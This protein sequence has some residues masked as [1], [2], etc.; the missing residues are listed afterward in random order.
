MQIPHAFEE[1]MTHA[2]GA[3][4]HSFRASLLEAPPVSIRINP[5]KKYTS[6]ESQQIPWCNQGRYLSK[7][8]SFT[9]DP[10]LHAGA[11]YVQEASS[12]FLE[13]V[14]SA[15]VNLS[16]PIRV[17]DLCAA[18]GGKSTH[19]L[20][21]LNNESLLVSNEVIRSRASILTEN[22]QKWGHANVVV[23]NNDPEGFQRVPG[24]FDVIIV[25]APCSGEGL[26][27]KDPSAM[28]EWSVEN[29]N[30]CSL[31]QRRILADVWAALKDGG[32]LIYSTC[33][34]NPEENEK[35]LSWFA[36]ENAIEFVDIGEL[37]AGVEKVSW[38]T[39]IGYRLMPGK[40]K[41]EGFFISAMKKTSNNSDFG[42]RKFRPTLSRKSIKEGSDWL[43]PHFHLIKQNELIL[44]WPVDFT[45]DIDQLI[46]TL[47][48]ISKGVAVAEMKHSKLIP[49]HALALCCDFNQH[50][51]E[52]IALN[53]NQAITFLR[54]ETLDLPGYTKGFTLVEFEGNALGWINHLGNR[55]NNLYPLNW[56]IKMGPSSPT[57]EQTNS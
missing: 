8:P 25:D 6:T 31:R 5:R 44:A 2:M 3:D 9:L 14:I 48:V 30:L 23:T 7:R 18:P 29:A 24:F 49:E 55:I 38:Q 39:S 20:S 37:P 22:I 10:H 33:T 1:R 26:F 56:R 52:S 34:Y 41:G 35:N 28:N 47:N 12:M 19:L 36:Q 42:H 57:V 50:S 32:T 40:V 43:P 4:W 54:K 27:R 17:L 53:Y 16:K 46:Q 51:V 21:L 13:A 45:D 11:Y 15:S